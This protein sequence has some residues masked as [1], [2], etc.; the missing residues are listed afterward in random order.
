[1]LKICTFIQATKTPVN[2]GIPSFF[3][4]LVSKSIVLKLTRHHNKCKTVS[5]VELRDA[6][7]HMTCNTL[8]QSLNQIWTHSDRMHHN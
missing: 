3:Q 7:F 5:Y 8:K 2:V 4:K 1:M 6:T